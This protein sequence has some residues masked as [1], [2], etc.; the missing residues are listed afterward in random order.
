MLI[1]NKET[2]RQITRRVWELRALGNSHE[3][4]VDLLFEEMGGEALPRG[5]RRKWRKKIDGFCMNAH[6]G[7][8]GVRKNSKVPELIRLAW[9]AEDDGRGAEEIAEQILVA[10]VPADMEQDPAIR[11]NFLKFVRAVACPFLE[12]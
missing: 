10:S 1:L 9:E 3:E 11:K 6:P 8:P 4:A 2:Y 7:E 5:Q 12:N